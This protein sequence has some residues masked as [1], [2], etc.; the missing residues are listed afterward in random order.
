MDFVEF[1]DRDL[2]TDA[3]ELTNIAWRLL[4]TDDNTDNICSLLCETDVRVS[5]YSNL[6]REILNVN[7]AK[8]NF[9]AVF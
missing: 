4:Q 3:T 5:H 6:F 8:L 1:S 7:L 2:L 9:S